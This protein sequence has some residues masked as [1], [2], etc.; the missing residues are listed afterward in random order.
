MFDFLIIKVEAA[1]LFTFGRIL[2]FH[3]TNNFIPQLFIPRLTFQMS[4]NR[5]YNMHALVYIKTAIR[6]SLKF[7][8]SILASRYVP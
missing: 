6:K 5:C 4:K 7:L 2:V 8:A 3:L 1:R